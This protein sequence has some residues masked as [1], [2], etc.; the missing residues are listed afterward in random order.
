MKIILLC[1]SDYMAIPAAL[2]LKSEGVLACVVIPEKYRTRLLPGFVQA[3]IENTMLH[4]ITRET[5]ESGLISLVKEYKADCIFVITLPWK[6]PKTVLA[7]PAYGCFNFHPGLLPKYKGADPIFWQ[8]KNGEK[9]GGITVHK[10]TEVVDEGPIMMVKKIPFIPG[11]TYGIHHARLGPL[12]A[13]MISELATLIKENAE[14]LIIQDID[15]EEAIFFKAPV[16]RQVTID[17]ENQSSSEVEALINATNPK[18]NGAFTSFRGMELTILEIG[19]ADVNDPPA[20][21]KAGTIVYADALYGPI[22]AC[23]DGKFVK[24]NAVCLPEGYISGSKLFSLGCTVGE[25]FI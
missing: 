3:G 25:R 21:N 12:A 18:Y 20:G 15:K 17:W 2:K 13:E 9:N 8:L 5:L 14:P 24:I 23:A 4:T 7:A 19:F 6:L 16:K 22:V 11:E 10:M 1:S